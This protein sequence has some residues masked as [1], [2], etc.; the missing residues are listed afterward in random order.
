MAAAPTREQ[1]L[2]AYYSFAVCKYFTLSPDLQL[3]H[4]PGYNRDRG[5]A[6]FVSLRAHLEL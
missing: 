5:P 2:E 4:N 3:V 1:I 6:R